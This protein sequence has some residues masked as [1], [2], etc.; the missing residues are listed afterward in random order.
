MYVDLRLGERCALYNPLED[1]CHKIFSQQLVWLQ[2]LGN[3]G[4]WCTFIGRIISQDSSGGL[5]HSSH[6]PRPQVWYILILYIQLALY[7]NYIIPPSTWNPYLLH[8]YLLFA[9]VNPLPVLWYH[10]R[11]SSLMD[12]K[13][14]AIGCYGYQIFTKHLH[15]FIFIYL[16]SRNTQCDAHQ[17]SYLDFFVTIYSQITPFH[18]WSTYSRRTHPRNLTHNV[19]FLT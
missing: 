16:Q 1:V 8:P 4:G 13:T 14:P 11:P 3:H 10:W 5:F 7:P 2:L 19:D 9:V 15:N 6:F 18:K 17:Y 12:M